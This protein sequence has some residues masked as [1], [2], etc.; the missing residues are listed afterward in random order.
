VIALDGPSAAGTRT[1][2]ADLGLRLA[3][4]VIEGDDFCRDMPEEQRWSL[5]TAQGV[6]EYFDW[7]RLRH[8]VLEPLRAG[9]PA[10]YHPFSRRPGGGQVGLVEDV[11]SSVDLR[12]R[13]D[14]H[15]AAF[16]VS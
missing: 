9:R 15:Q 10:R 11:P 16:T 13:P 7:Q 4:S 8:E 3:A 6:E 5:D 2:A 12:W 14:D 1:L